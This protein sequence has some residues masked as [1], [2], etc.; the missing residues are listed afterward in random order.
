[1]KP[2]PQNLVQ[3]AI[4]RSHG[5]ICSFSGEGD[6]K[7]VQKIRERFLCFYFLQ[8]KA[9]RLWTRWLGI[10]LT[11]VCSEWWSQR[12]PPLPAA[13]FWYAPG[14]PC[15]CGSS[16]DGSQ[17]RSGYAVTNV[18]IKASCLSKLTSIHVSEIQGSHAWAYTCLSVRRHATLKLLTDTAACLG[19]VLTWDTTLHPS[20]KSL[21][22]NCYYYA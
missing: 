18:A 1:M 16:A 19:Y 12:L 21:R 20:A 2:K 8:S 4:L 3:T 10:T 6:L 22:L 15:N 17:N 5:Y 7:S 14:A 11:C 13:A 9:S